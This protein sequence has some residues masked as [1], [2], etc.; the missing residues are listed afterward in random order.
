M[1][2]GKYRPSLSHFIDSYFAP[3]RRISKFRKP[4]KIIISSSVPLRRS[5]I[6]K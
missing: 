2:T 6:V 4:E 1:L 5:R 3:L